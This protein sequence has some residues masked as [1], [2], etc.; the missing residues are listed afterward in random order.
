MLS[1]GI[2]TASNSPWASPVVLVKKKDGSTRFCVDYRKL[3][4]V[5]RKDSY[6][7]PRIDDILDKLHGTAYFSTL[8]LMSGYWQC[9]LTPVAKEKTAFITFGGLYE[10]EVMPFGLSNAPSTF[11]RL[12][13]TTLRDLNWKSCLIYLDD[14]IVFSH[15][16]EEYLYHLAQVFDRLREANLR[17]KP[18]K[19]SFGRQEVNYLG[20]VI[21]ANGI[22]PDPSKI[23]LV[24][25]F[26]QPKTVRQVRSFLGLANYYRRFVQD[27]SKI[28]S[29]LHDLTKKHQQIHLER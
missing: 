20:H 7:L 26:P 6:P 11:Q 1:Q 29:P 22:L 8:D 5:T 13:E 10:F 21:S 14:V 27:F 17:L 12:M 23:E 4:W 16:F 3:N 18:S 2:I 9:Q 25:N 15:T 19:C 28:A 24:R